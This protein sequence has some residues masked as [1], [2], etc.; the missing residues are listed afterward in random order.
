MFVAIIFSEYIDLLGIT[1]F[2][3]KILKKTFVFDLQTHHGHFVT[4]IHSV[5]QD[6]VINY[7]VLGL[8][9]FQDAK[10]FCIY[11]CI[12]FSSLT[13]LKIKCIL[14]TLECLIVLYSLIEFIQFRFV[15]SLMTSKEQKTVKLTFVLSFNITTSLTQETQSRLRC[16]D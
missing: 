7:S 2:N 10:Y 3:H 6:C 5:V 13:K 14:K 4:K 16:R 8:S 1:I 9:I 11:L 15:K 12:Y